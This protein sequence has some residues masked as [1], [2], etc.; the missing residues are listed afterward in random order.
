MRQANAAAV[1]AMIGEVLSRLGDL[2]GALAEYQ[3]YRSVNERLAEA[4]PSD[5]G[6]Q[7][8][9]MVAHDRIGG[10]R[11]AK[12]DSAGALAEYQASLAIAEVLAAADPDD[13]GRRRDVQG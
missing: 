12:G 2:D 9:L 13:P 5:E 4:D 3:I 10:V 1:H 6:R 11:L 7:A 8:V